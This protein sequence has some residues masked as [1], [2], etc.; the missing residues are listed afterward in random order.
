MFL[1]KTLPV[2]WLWH[3]LTSAVE[4]YN[5]LN[6]LSTAL[7]QKLTLPEAGAQSHPEVPAAPKW[8][9][10]RDCPT[11]LASRAK[12][13]SCAASASASTAPVSVTL[14]RNPCYV[15]LLGVFCFS[16]VTVLLGQME[17][18][19][20]GCDSCLGQGSRVAWRWGFLWA[21][22]V[23]SCPQLLRSI[24]TQMTLHVRVL[25]AL[26]NTQSH[27]SHT[28]VLDIWL[29]KMTSRVGSQTEG[30]ICLNGEKGL[31]VNRYLETMNF[32][33]SPL[34]PY[35][36]LWKWLLNHWNVTW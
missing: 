20:S 31:P 8:T 12:P 11:F 5:F 16:P 15:L 18:V 35:L 19:A 17:T 36:F 3:P 7:L 32:L 6:S 34:C 29:Q 1:A 21:V 9:Q 26:E 25:D 2:R 28:W 30:D 24:Q 13:W 10:N 22:A 27:F 33:L 23:A 14:F 4:L